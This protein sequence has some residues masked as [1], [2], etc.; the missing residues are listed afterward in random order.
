METDY[1]YRA[2][3]RSTRKCPNKKCAKRVR[4]KEFACQQCWGRL[5][6]EFRHRIKSV[7]SH[8]PWKETPPTLGEV[9]TALKELERQANEY[10]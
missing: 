6:T 9:Q 7:I 5:P 3:Y 2:K 8:E 1:E 4:S 10:W